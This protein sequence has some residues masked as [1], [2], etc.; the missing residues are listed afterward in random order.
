VVLLRNVLI[1][2]YFFP[3]M[4]E[5]GGIRLHGLAK[6]LP[7]HGWNPIILTPVLPGEPD[8]RFHVIQTSYDD[9]KFKW[10]KRLRLNPKETLNKQFG[11]SRAKD[12]PSIIDL[13]AY[14]PREIILYP[15]SIRGWYRHAIPAGDRLLQSEQ[16]DAVLSSSYPAT[17]HLIAKALA[18]KYRVPWIADLRD[19]WTQNP[20]SNHCV[21]RRF[22][23][24]RLEI[25][26]L[27]KASALVTVS[28]P[29][30][31]DLSRLHIHKPVHVITN[32]FDPE[33]ACFAPPE[34][35][36]KFTITYTGVLY[37][38]QREPSI[39]FKALQ[40]LMN[41]CVIDPKRVEVRFFGSQ[42]PWLFDEI[43]DAN[44]EDIVKV[45]GFVPRDQALQKQRESQLLLLLLWNNPQ[46]KG[47]YTGKVFEYLAARR[48]I[49]ALNGPD[50]SVVK[51][52]L[53]ETQAGHYLSS[54]KDL[55]VVLS[56]YYL[57]Y[58]KAGAVPPT[59]ASA[60]SKYSQLEMAK[61]FADLLDKVQT[62]GL[63]HPTSVAACSLNS[64]GN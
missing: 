41:N 58:I 30:A 1:I 22:A 50:E 35:T 23:E 25:R 44:L 3:P 63:Q 47:V 29:L 48:P 7:E 32:G 2:T 51:D 37:D 45:L 38:G 57:E 28:K 59:E 13:L 20:Y 9:I 17:C 39:L 6:Y 18:E 11:I 24:K 15:D 56:K 42:D 40:N 60:T 12:R 26:T 54:L 34:L 8:P 19:L 27:S 36:D 10:K 55:E 53:N 52:L 61:K 49:I 33:D 64:R 4:P 21:L 62:E 16:I 46:E 43:E 5:I 31:D 14:L